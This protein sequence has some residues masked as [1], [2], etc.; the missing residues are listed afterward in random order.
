MFMKNRILI[1]MI[2]G[3][4]SLS[5][6][7]CGDTTTT[8]D[9]ND[10]S[11]CDGI[12]YTDIATDNNLNALS[13]E[14]PI[15][16]LYGER[17]ITV[18]IGTTSILDNGDNIKAS[19]P[20]DGDL[21]NQV[22]RD[23]DV[24]LNQV[25]EYHIKY[26]VEDNDGNQDIKCRKVIVQGTNTD[27][28]GILDNG[29]YNTDNGNYDNGNYNTDNTNNGGYVDDYTGGQGNND[30][31]TPIGG[32]NSTGNN[33]Y[34]SNSSDLDTFIAWYDNTCGGTFNRSLYNETTKTYN[35]TI[36][37]SNRGLTSIDLSPLR[38]FDGINEIDLSHN[39]LTNIDFSPIRDINTLWKL[40]ISYNTQTLKNK[41]D[42]VSERNALFRYF[43][44]LHGGD[45]KTT[46]LW[47]GFKPRSADKEELRIEF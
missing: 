35:G 19:D 5:F 25:G 21:T 40:N 45:G 9:P 4:T 7:G 46:G 2:L 31:G 11:M 1:S 38:M 22:Q 17:I 16:T 27:I 37:C 47:I 20:Q 41:Y 10:F 36:D 29:N 18:P 23:D 33:N 26:S 43:T 13:G 42:T 34:S 28:N 44:N 32:D 12:G 6:I 39:K 24:N 3:A 8:N 14:N 30:L 15:I